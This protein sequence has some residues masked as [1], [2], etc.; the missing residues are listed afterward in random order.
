MLDI[1]TCVVALV[2]IFRTCLFLYQMKFD[3]KKG[4]LKEKKPKW[5]LIT[6]V[7]VDIL[8]ILGIISLA[9]IHFILGN[10]LIYT[11]W[12]LAFILNTINIIDDRNIFTTRQ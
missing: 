5:L 3:R 9:I 1:F 7:I 11:L 6:S 4:E 10:M 12:S 2:C 8:T